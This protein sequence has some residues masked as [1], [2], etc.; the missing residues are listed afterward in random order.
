MV[1]LAPSEKCI[2]MSGEISHDAGNSSILRVRPY[3]G[4]EPML[5]MIAAKRIHS[6]ASL[7]LMMLPPS[8]I[9]VIAGVAGQGSSMQVREGG[10]QE[11]A[12][13]AVQVGEREAPP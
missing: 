2:F 12:M 5:L 7:T 1:P 8:G 6:V 10:M 4:S 3:A 13:Q 11:K 9:V